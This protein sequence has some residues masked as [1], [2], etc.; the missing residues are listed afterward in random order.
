MI[1]MKDEVKDR[2][3]MAHDKTNGW[4]KLR[5]SMKSWGT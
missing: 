2:S 4:W 5:G 3:M 1:C